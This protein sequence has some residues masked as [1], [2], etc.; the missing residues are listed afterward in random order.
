ME[1]LVLKSWPNTGKSTSINQFYNRVL[2]RSDTEKSIKAERHKGKNNDEDL[3]AILE[4]EHKGHK[5]KIGIASDGDDADATT[6]NL[7]RFFNE[8]PP[9]D[10]A[11]VASHTQRETF[12]VIAEFANRKHSIVMFDYRSHVG[13]DEDGEFKDKET[14]H[15]DANQHKA[16]LLYDRIFR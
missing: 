16:N 11:V 1:I 3:V 8:T 9:C 6:K 15:K 12:D 10:Y 13:K 14:N 2:E 5:V 7:T 4:T